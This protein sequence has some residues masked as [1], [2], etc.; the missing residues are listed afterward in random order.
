MNVKGITQSEAEKAQMLDRAAACRRE[1]A[2]R[3]VAPMNAETE[4]AGADGLGGGEPDPL[5]KLAAEIGYGGDVPEDDDPGCLDAL[6]DYKNAL[7]DRCRSLEECLGEVGKALPTED[8]WDGGPGR[9]EYIAASVDRC[10][11]VP[12]PERSDYLRH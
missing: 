3:K 4:M 11:L 5:D 12:R 8:D 9:L 6:I 7:E 10:G 2:A 1:A